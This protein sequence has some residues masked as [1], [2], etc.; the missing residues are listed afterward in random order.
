MILKFLYWFPRILAILAILF[1]V[2]FSFDVY[3]GDGNQR[4]KFTAF[5]IHNIP[6]IMFIIALIVAWRYEIIGGAIFILFSF[7]LAIFFN[8][9]SGNPAALAVISPFFLAGILFILH[10]VLERGYT[11]KDSC[12]VAF[13]FPCS[14]IPEIGRASCRERV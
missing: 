1:I 9:F 14:A 5:M 10:Q 6:A 12:S 11:K 7:A 8:V 4:Y 2:M 13:L 3:A